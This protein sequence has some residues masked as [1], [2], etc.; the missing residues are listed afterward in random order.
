[1]AR[2]MIRN[3][4]RFISIA[5]VFSALS[6]MLTLKTLANTDTETDWEEEDEV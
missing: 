3:I 1:M 5:I 6:S 2:K 4:W